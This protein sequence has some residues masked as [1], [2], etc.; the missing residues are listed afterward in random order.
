MLICRGFLAI[1][2]D[3]AFTVAAIPSMRDEFFDRSGL[4]NIRLSLLLLSRQATRVPAQYRMPAMVELAGGDQLQQLLRW[5][6]QRGDALPDL[7]AVVAL[8]DHGNRDLARVPGVKTD[9]LQLK[10]LSRPLQTRG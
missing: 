6:R 9:L 10:H 3:S 5:L 2:R 7:D 8:L 1:A 4:V